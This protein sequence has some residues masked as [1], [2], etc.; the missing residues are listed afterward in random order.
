LQDRRRYR[1]RRRSA[2]TLRPVHGARHGP[3]HEGYR[4]SQ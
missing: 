2:T 4:L 1:R 3:L